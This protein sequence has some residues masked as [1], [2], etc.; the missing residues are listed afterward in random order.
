VFFTGASTKYRKNLDELAESLA[1]SDKVHYLGFVT[2]TELQVI[3]RLATAMIFPSKFEGF[4]LP[5]LEAFY[6]KLPVLA[7]NATTLPE[8]AKDG[9]LYF[10]PDS[11]T[12]LA[13]LMEE[14]QEGTELR[15][16]LAER[17]TRV[18]SQYSMKNMAGR[19]Q[20]LYERAAS[21]PHLRDDTLRRRTGVASR[22]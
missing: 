13:D 15:H 21:Q 2:A 18:L 5:V 9:A 8:I 1:V 16:E 7:A 11:A 10:D 20:E 4:G 14:V 3:C 6:A 22:A 12:E 17:G 19:F